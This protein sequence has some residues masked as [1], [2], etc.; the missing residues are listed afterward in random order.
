MKKIAAII[1]VSSIFAACLPAWAAVVNLDYSVYSTQIA[2]LDQ[3][4]DEINSLI[5]ECEENGI[6]PDYEIMRGAVL[7]KYTQFFKDELTNGVSYR[8]EENGY[9]ES[10]V[11]HIYDYNVSSL[12]KIADEA[13]GNLNAYL[14]GTK[15]PMHVPKVVTSPTE[16]DGKTVTAQT[17]IDGVSERNKVFLNGFGHYTAFDH[18]DFF[19]KTGANFIQM[20]IGLSSYLRPANGITDWLTGYYMKPDATIELTE[21]ESRHGSKS[22]KMTNKTE[23]TENYYMGLNQPIKVEPKTS[24]TYRFYAKGSNIQNFVYKTTSS[25]TFKRITYSDAASLDNWT[26]YEVQFTTGD[27][28]TVD[29]V[30]LLTEGPTDAIYID[31]VG[32]YKTGSSVNLLSN[33][34]FEKTDAEDKILDI[35]YEKLWKLE[36][37][38]KEAEEKNIKIDLLLAMHYFVWELAEQYPDILEEGDSFGY[39]LAHEAAQRACKMHA[40]TIAALVDGYECINSIC[41]ANEPRTCPRDG[42]DDSYYKDDYALY[43]EEIY[44]TEERYNELNGTSYSDFSQIPFPTSGLSGRTTM[45]SYDYTL[46]ADKI[47]TQWVELIANSVKAVTDIPVH[48][49][50][51]SYT[52]WADESDSRWLIAIGFDPQEYH[53]YVDIN[54]ND[55][56]LRIPANYDGDISAFM[57]NRGVQ[58]SMWYDFLTSIKDA[59]VFNSEDHILANGDKLYRDEHNKLIDAAQWMG[60]VHG[61]TMTATWIF[62]RTESREET[63]ESIMYRPDLYEN[64][65]EINMDLNRLADE[66]YAVM[67]APKNIGI[68]YSET[69]RHYNKYHMNTMYK[70]YENCL[71]NGLKPGFVVESQLDAMDNYE[72]MIIPY[73]THVTSSV[74][75]KLKAYTQNGGKLIVVGD[76]CL[77]YDERLTAH[78]SADIS[79]IIADA[80]EV[81]L[82]LNGTYEVTVSQAELFGAIYDEAD[83]LGI[84]DIEIRDNATGERTMDVEYSMAELDGA[85]II[86]ICN[87]DWDADKNVSI[88]IDG[89]R[90]QSATELRSGEDVLSDIELKSYKPILLK[91]GGDDEVETTETSISNI[92]ISEDRI[93]CNVTAGE[94]LENAL[95]AAAV[96]DTSGKLESA[97]VTDIELLESGESSEYYSDST[98][99][100]DG[101]NIRLMLWKKTL[102][103]II[104]PAAYDPLSNTDYRLDF[105]KEE[106]ANELQVVCS[107]LLE[108]GGTVLNDSENERAYFEG[109]DQDTAFLLPEDIEKS[110][111]VIEADLTYQKNENHR[112]YGISFGYVFGYQDSGNFTALRYNPENGTIIM[113]NGI[114]GARYSR[115]AEKGNGAATMLGEQETAHLKLI[116]N[117]GKMEFFVNGELG[118]AYSSPNDSRTADGVASTQKANNFTKSGR[119]GI[120][121]HADRTTISV[122]NIRVREIAEEDISYYSNSYMDS[123]LPI[124]LSNDMSGINSSFFASHSLTSS[125]WGKAAYEVNASN[126]WANTGNYSSMTLCG[127]YAIDMNFALKN[128]L[129]DSRWI[130]IA[131]GMHVNDGAAYYN[132]A[133]VRENG[134][135]FIEQKKVTADGSESAVSASNSAKDS[136]AATISD[137]EKN[138]EYDGDTNK[139]LLSYMPSGYTSSD[140]LDVNPRR[141]NMRLEVS[142]NIA[143]LTF[144]GKTISCVIDKNSVDGFFGIRAAGTAANIYS[145]R[146]YPIY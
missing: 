53:K 70:A 100:T 122:D 90:V 41:I 125:T 1:T 93:F 97:S 118:Y 121:S 76:G 99:S 96:Y 89:V 95:L 86:S 135:L 78:N 39:R 19:G 116:V 16:I 105:I 46:F 143:T 10:D 40:E 20:E 27:E 92:K 77:A 106:S 128:P 7:E 66:V 82:S 72:L 51:M 9:S 138:S 26:K 60:A 126:T 22:I 61:R 42:G 104:T 109:V 140:P 44:G 57:E 35:D 110:D 4:T 2:E 15:E 34:G 101:K 52:T 107:G 134:E 47:G 120:F 24:Y 63:Y 6:S 29:R 137:N 85:K 115:Y 21:E 5:A 49:K 38:L 74:I 83:S 119:I 75:D 11:K 12:N 146:A 139:Y 68:L 102:E 71:Y 88:Y 130:G 3:K 37:I 114:N 30:Y 117:D 124:E 79:S 23:I 133:G 45:D 142:G 81:E 129:N 103:P 13:I 94:R 8:S 54:G 56:G 18:F 67:E 91:V 55:A 65:S 50:Q 111:F 25:G 28:Q 36:E 144:G 112:G 33:G 98:A 113:L 73:A 14:L 31:D 136:C 32:L 108:G 69:T 43:L 58:Q 17:E 80:A 84:T 123:T 131:F 62:D 127:D 132:I 64:I 48:V 87:Y 145:L 59:P 141:H